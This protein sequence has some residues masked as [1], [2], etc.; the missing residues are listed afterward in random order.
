M[1]DPAPPLA[2]AA[3]PE[4]QSGESA[5]RALLD[6]LPP[7]EAELLRAHMRALAGE[8]LRQ[9]MLLAGSLMLAARDVAIDFDA[10]AASLPATRRYLGETRAALASGGD[11]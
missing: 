10:L 1:T 2:R 3:L 4:T 6:R 7:R 9:G 5:I 11:D 8:A